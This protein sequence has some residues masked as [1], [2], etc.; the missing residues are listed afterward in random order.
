MGGRPGPRELFDRVNYDA[1]MAHVARRVNDQSIDSECV[2]KTTCSPRSRTS[3]GA[4]GSRPRHRCR[5]PDRN[6]DAFKTTTKAL[7]VRPEELSVYR[8]VPSHDRRMRT[9]IRLSGSEVARPAGSIPAFELL[10]IVLPRVDILQ[11]FAYDNSKPGGVD[12]IVAETS[13]YD[14]ACSLLH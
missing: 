10:K 4:Q 13:S 12:K 3:E 5:H 11:L 1:L 6:D 8:D 7:A 14:G 2:S 9:G